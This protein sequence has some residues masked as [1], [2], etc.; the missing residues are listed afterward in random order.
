MF[1]L[2]YIYSLFI[3]NATINSISTIIS[4]N[5]SMGIIFS[6][7]HLIT[8]EW[9]FRNLIFLPHKPFFP[10]K[11]ETIKEVL[12]F[13]IELTYYDEY[14]FGR[15]LGANRARDWVFDTLSKC[16]FVDE[17]L[18]IRVLGVINDSSILMGM[19]KVLLKKKRL[20]FSFSQ[21]LCLDKKV[22]EKP[23]KEV[24]LV[25]I[26]DSKKLISLEKLKCF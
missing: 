19:L 2:I 24:K 23:V 13:C 9:F 7:L 15:K 26:I 18:Q 16:D 20:N 21:L 5:N 1:S 17:N 14:I 12:E 8:F 3:T 11:M 4:T 22:R 6:I 10:L 25:D